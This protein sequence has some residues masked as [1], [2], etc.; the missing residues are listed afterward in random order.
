[1]FRYLTAGESHGPQLTAIVEGIPAGLK[2]TEEQI[3]QDLIR[4][5]GGYGRGDRMKIETD[6]VRLLSGVRWGETLGSPIT[7]VVENH[8]WANWDE[9]M[10][11]YEEHRDESIAV[12]RA[13]PGHA[14]LPGALKYNHR[15]VRNILERSSARETGVRVAVGA[16]AKA[17]LAAFGIRVDGCVV[18]LGGVKAT[19]PNVSAEELKKLV[20]ASPLYT[21]D[22][23]A[24]KDMIAMIDWA[25]SE[26]NTLGGVVEVRVTGVPIGLGSHVQWDRRLDAR[27]AAAVMSIQAFKGVEIG[28][29][30]EAARTPGSKVHDEIFY[31]AARKGTPGNPTGFYRT[32]NNAGGLEGGISNGEEL[33]VRGAMKPIPT[34]YTPLKSVDIVTKEAYEATVERSDVCAVPAASV[35]AE[36]VVAIEIANAFMEKFGGDSIAET[37]RNYASYLE[38]LREY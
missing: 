37:S 13:R 18:E 26:G 17:Y 36:T 35:V 5:Q 4:R 31:D 12:T 14:D 34:L 21:Y 15:D 2:L 28:A 11:P 8:D 1:M 10:S 9:K 19:R 32:G 16:L 30:F 27:L 6:R 3:N 25:H 20:A 22:P 29:G 38:Y 33:V 7:L 23:A 24:E